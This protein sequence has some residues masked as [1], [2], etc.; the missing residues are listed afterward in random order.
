MVSPSASIGTAQQTAKAASS[1]VMLRQG[2][3]SSSWTYGAAVMIAFAPARTM[4]SLRRS[5]I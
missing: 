5:A 3:T 2:M 1:R 4:P